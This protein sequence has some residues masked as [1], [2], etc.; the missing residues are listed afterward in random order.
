MKAIAYAAVLLGLVSTAL[1][2]SQTLAPSPTESYGC[3]PHGDHWHCEGP[4][5][6]QSLATTTTGAALTTSTAAHDHDEDD[7]H[8]HDHDHDDD[9]DGSTDATGTGSLK[10]SPTESYGCVAHGDHWHCEGPIT[11]S[12]AGTASTLAT[13]TITSSSTPAASSIGT[14]DAA[15]ASSTSTAGAPRLELAGLGFA[16]LAAAAALAF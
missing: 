4:R 16:G 10:P 2:Q 12:S 13:T 14:T 1:G 5:T 7:D 9:H 15:A 6:A 11:A 3:E 8:D